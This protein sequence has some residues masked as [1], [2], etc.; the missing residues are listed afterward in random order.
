MHL[1]GTKGVAGVKLHERWPCSSVWTQGSVWYVCIQV[2]MQYPAVRGAAVVGLPH[3]RLGETVAALL[4]LREA[5]SSARNTCTGPPPLPTHTHT[6]HRPWGMGCTAPPLSCIFQ[7][8][9]PTLSRLHNH[10]PPAGKLGWDSAFACLTHCWVLFLHHRPQN[11]TVFHLLNR[12]S[13]A[14][15]KHI[16]LVSLLATA[17]RLYGTTYSSWP[18]ISACHRCI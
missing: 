16:F 14:A 12:R 10:S 4:Q 5:P 13:A 15:S 17:Y 6:R 7:T 9:P 3:E 2:L 1:L 8:S 11:L 18:E